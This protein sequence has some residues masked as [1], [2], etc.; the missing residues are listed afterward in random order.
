M[1]IG[2]YGYL[3]KPCE[4]DELVE[5]IEGTG[6]KKTKAETKDNETSNVVPMIP[7][8]GRLSRSQARNLDG[9]TVITIGKQVLEFF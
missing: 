6:K 7:D 1:R 3:T 5:K 9:T 2:A 8:T 4:M